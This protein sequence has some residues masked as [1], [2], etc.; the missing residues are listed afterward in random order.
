MGVVLL[1][2]ASKKAPYLYRN[3]ASSSFYFRRSVPLRLRSLIHKNEIKVSLKTG[4]K[5]KA[6]LLHNYLMNI[7]EVI[8]STGNKALIKKLQIDSLT[9]NPDGSFKVEGLKTD[10]DNLE[11]DLSI[12]DA[13][14]LTNNTSTA[15]TPEKAAGEDFM[16]F[17]EL[18]EKYFLNKS[19]MDEK[20]K[21]ENASI[22]QIFSEIFDNPE[23][24][25][26]SHPMV[27]NFRDIMRDQFPKNARKK[28]PKMTAKEVL[29]LHHSEEDRLSTHTVNKYLGR[30]GLLFSFA[31]NEG[32]MPENY[33][34]GKRIK[35][36]VDAKEQRKLFLD[37]EVLKILGKI[38]NE[39][40]EDLDLYWLFYLGAFEGMR[41]GEI[42]QLQ[43][44]DIKQISDIWCIDINNN[45]PLK[46]C[47]SSGSKRIIP[48]HS[49]VIEM[50]FVEYVE[51]R[52]NHEFL[53]NWK[54][55]KK[56]GWGHYSSKR[57]NYFIKDVCNIKV[58]GKTFH[59]LR[60]SVATK[61]INEL[62]EET[63]RE[64][65]TAVMGHSQTG[66]TFR[67]YGKAFKPEK[68]VP[69]VEAIQYGE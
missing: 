3:T 32:Y 12:L 38:E 17:S 21:L 34:E 54:C 44:D 50:G 33:A 35:G 9:R 6:I 43:P 48:V 1:Y 63:P 66:E 13:L 45:H 23:L 5:S 7:V 42:C 16:R 64:L 31:V 37:K 28:F 52:K 47:K 56:N 14:G 55:Q 20:T 36:K 46:K 51:T 29:R 41:L 15:S 60:H 61:L 30:I 26:I 4:E 69:I 10:P 25:T 39:K 57:A 53:F 27:R 67:R 40:D 19:T 24:N 2:K 59:S 49:K 11:Q 65:I 8:F 58:N 22:Y 62:S 18:V 68:L